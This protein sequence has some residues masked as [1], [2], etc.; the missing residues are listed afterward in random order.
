MADGINAFHCRLLTFW[1]CM[2][3]GGRRAHVAL[4]GYPGWAVL[5]CD[6]AHGL[7]GICLR[8]DLWPCPHYPP[9]HPEPDHVAVSASLVC[10]A[11]PAACLPAAPCSWG[12]DGMVD[13]SPVGW[14]AECSCGAPFPD[15]PGTGVAARKIVPDAVV[16]V[17]IPTLR[18]ESCDRQSEKQRQHSY[19]GAHSP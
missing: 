6:A 12:P 18:S 9:C 1:V 3:G 14:I 5:R 8:D 15:H 13:R 2:A 4:C 17:S 10:A 19:P 11:A 7:C 16:S